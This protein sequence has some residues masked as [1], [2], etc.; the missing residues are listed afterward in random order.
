MHTSSVS[1]QTSLSTYIYKI[2]HTY[3]DLSC[4]SPK[5]PNS[6]CTLGLR[7][8]RG[9]S[10]TDILV[11]KC[12]SWGRK[13]EVHKQEY[14][15]EPNRIERVYVFVFFHLWYPQNVSLMSDMTYGCSLIIGKNLN[16]C[17]RLQRTFSICTSVWQ[18]PLF[19]GRLLCS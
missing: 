10:T 7:T 12:F 5:S 6:N 3:Q 13:Y 4:Y 9:T 14:S 8:D 11:G 15:Q 17:N 18:F 2:N 1:L 19:L 16:P